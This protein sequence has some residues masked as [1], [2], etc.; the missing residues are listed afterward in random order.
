MFDLEQSIADWRKQML[1]AGIETPVP[2]EELELHLRE[3]IE[4]QTE[5][6][7]SAQRAFESAIQKI[8]QPAA[9]KSEFQKTN[10]PTIERKSITAIAGGI[11]AALVGFIL[12]WAGTV[13]CRYVGKMTSETSVLLVLGIILVF[14]GGGISFVASK[15]K[16]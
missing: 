6:G 13:Q 8:G 14:D 16:A 10:A 3:E 5:S 12:L 15:R 7:V 4:R 9:L 2:L 1:A 11:L